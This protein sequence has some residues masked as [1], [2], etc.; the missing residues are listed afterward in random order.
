RLR[1]RERQ[2]NAAVLEAVFRAQNPA[3][4]K[5][6]AADLHLLPDTRLEKLRRAR[7]EKNLPRPRAEILRRARP[8]LRAPQARIVRLDAETRDHRMPLRR[9]EAEQH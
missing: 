4:D 3:D 9:H 2:K 1:L 7:A 8:P 5:L 6:A